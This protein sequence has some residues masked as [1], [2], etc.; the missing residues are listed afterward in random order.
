MES[1]DLDASEIAVLS[2][3]LSHCRSGNLTCFPS[4]G[5]IGFLLKR[6]KAWV[7]PIINCLETKGYISIET[8]RNGKKTYEINT[9]NSADQPTEQPVNTVQRSKQPSVLRIKSMTY[10]PTPDQFREIRALAPGVNHDR[11]LKAFG[12][13]NRQKGNS[14]EL[15][16]P[17]HAAFL[18]WLLKAKPDAPE[19][20]QS[21][22]MA[23]LAQSGEALL[24]LVDEQ[25]RNS[26]E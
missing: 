5:R 3:L 8:A 23:R 26:G 24:R 15:G 10:E 21:K 19:S 12:L 11:E 16:E 9:L 22:R 1:D 4:Y 2:C 13:W 18:R 25:D 17:I 20:G 7:S 14:Y 6:S